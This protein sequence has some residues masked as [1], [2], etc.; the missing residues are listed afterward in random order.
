MPAMQLLMEVIFLRRIRFREM[1]HDAL[2]IKNVIMGLQVGN[3]RFQR[4]TF[5]EANA[6]HA[7]IYRQIYLQAWTIGPQVLSCRF[8]PSEGTNRRHHLVISQ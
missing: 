3:R 8:Q 6:S 7:S 5:T 1:R 4:G 2:I